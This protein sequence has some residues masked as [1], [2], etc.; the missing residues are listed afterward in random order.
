MG[1]T[2][3]W[4]DPTFSHYLKIHAVK[5]AID[6]NTPKKNKVKPL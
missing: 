5:P 3:I 6:K 4:T 1:A 2:A